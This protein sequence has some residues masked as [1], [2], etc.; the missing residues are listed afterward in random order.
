MK[1]HLSF[2]TDCEQVEHSADWP[3]DV[4]PWVS[5]EHTGAAGPAGEVWEQDPDSYQDRPQLQ[6][7]LP[8]PACRLLHTKGTWS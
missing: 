1:W 8:I 3:D 7:A 6:N 4:L 2:S 5:G